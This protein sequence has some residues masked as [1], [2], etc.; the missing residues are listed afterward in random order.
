[1]LGGD[2]ADDADAVHMS[3]LSPSHWQATCERGGG[4]LAQHT[5]HMPYE[6][7]GGARAARQRRRGLRCGEE[8]HCILSTTCV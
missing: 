4:F 7:H 5:H 2:D 3:S 1:M 6:R 8:P